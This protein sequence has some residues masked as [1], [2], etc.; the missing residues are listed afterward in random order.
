MPY[1]ENGVWYP[2][3]PAGIP[4]AGGGGG[5]GDGTGAPP[6]NYAP[7]EP[8]EQFPGYNPYY[9]PPVGPQQPTSPPS[10][11]PGT[12]PITQ[13]PPIGFDPTTAPGVDVF[14]AGMIGPLSRFFRGSVR[15]SPSPAQVL[16]R[17]GINAVF[18]NLQQ[19]A[20]FFARPALNV[21]AE[22]TPQDLAAMLRRTIPSTAVRIAAGLGAVVGIGVDLLWPSSLG[23]NDM[24]SDI[25]RLQEVDLFDYKRLTTPTMIG[26][27]NS[28]F[29][30]GQPVNTGVDALMGEPAG[31]PEIQARG[32]SGIQKYLE[33]RARRIVRGALPPELRQYVP[34]SSIDGPIRPQP[35]APATTP[36]QVSVPSTAPRRGTART[37]PRPGRLFTFGGLGTLVLL[38]EAN[39]RGRSS[40]PSTAGSPVPAI[41]EPTPTPTPTPLTPLVPG[42]QSYAPYYGGAGVD[43]GYCVP[44]PRGPRRK[45]LE[46]APV[47]Y[48]GGRR[49]GKAAGTKCLRWEAPRR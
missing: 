14:G 28:R 35:T 32:R 43:T 40:S 1:G 7:P 10:P 33:D 31:F 13:P 46:R 44:R 17:T 2:D 38:I 21:A 34:R 45:C 11:G 3:T 20:S 25:E 18:R 15:R 27:P 19:G 22:A 41:P 36:G 29:P 49:K 42:V 5:G 8:G 47:K 26:I 37:G 30:L 6:P 9:P 4:G 48:S 39:R 23:R 24:I 16:I 12:P